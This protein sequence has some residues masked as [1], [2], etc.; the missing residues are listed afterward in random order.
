VSSSVD[1]PGLESSHVPPGRS[2]HGRSAQAGLTRPPASR[3]DL[4]ESRAERKERTR[5]ALV[6]GTLA[7][8]E[9]R[10]FASLSLREV[11]R[12]VGVVPT[13]FYRHFD[14]MDDLGVALV[15]E[16]TRTLRQLIRDARRNPSDDP[17]TG[18]VEILVRYVRER[19]P[20]F[21]FLIRER[22]GG[23]SAV[24]RAIATTLR[25]FTN[26]LTIDL[27][28]MP[29][30]Q[31]WSTEDLEMAADLMVASMLQTIQALVDS[32]HRRP[33]DAAEIV[34]RAERQLRLIALGLAGWRSA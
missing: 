1:A 9:S 21:R 26:E 3:R 25:L 11:A 14:S 15:D 8:L 27:A 13:A 34:R 18:S 16:C 30:L 28:R 10:S 32:D 7:L 33:E 4:G 12:S 5:Q 23:V 2:G 17:I 6:D 24:T 22:S 31:S 20:D 29:A 19:E